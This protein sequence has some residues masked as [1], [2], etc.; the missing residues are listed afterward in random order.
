MEIYIS[1]ASAVV[2]VGAFILSGYAIQ[3]ARRSAEASER[4]AA[5]AEL[6]VPVPTP[7]VSWKVTGSQ[8]SQGRTLRHTG[9]ETATGLRRAFVPPPDVDVI[10]F[11]PRGGTVIAEGSIDF[12]VLDFGEHTTPCEIFLTWDGQEEPVAVPLP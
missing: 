4:Q 9:T 10:D 1:A 11:D 5:A 12:K 8:G 2:A 7:P 6:M 3:Y